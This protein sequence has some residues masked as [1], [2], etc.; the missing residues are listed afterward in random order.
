MDQFLFMGCL[1]FMIACG[2]HSSKQND[3][4]QLDPYL[5]CLKYSGQAENIIEEETEGE[6]QARF[7]KR[8]A[9]TFGSK[10]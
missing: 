6:A 8:T 1:I 4:S 7:S 5:D 9:F 2:V 10:G 3:E